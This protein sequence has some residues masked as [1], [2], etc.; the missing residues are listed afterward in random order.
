MRIAF[1]V[2]AWT[3]TS[4][5]LAV[6][7]PTAS[8]PAPVMPTN[9]AIVPVTHNR[10]PQIYDWPTR[11]QEVL[12][13]LKEKKPDLIL[14]G[15]SII[16]YWGGE[17]K[18]RIARAP[19]VW[20]QYFGKR[21]AVNLG[22][23]WDRTENVL[24]RLRNGE[25][26]G[27]APKAAVILIGVNNLGLNTAEEIAAGIAAICAEVHRRLPTTNIL[28]LGILPHAN[29]PAKLVEVNR[30]STALNGKDGVTFL[31]VGSAFHDAAGQFRRDLFLD[32]LHPNATGC[33]VLCDAIEPTLARLMGP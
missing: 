21:N 10:E 12:A 22:F 28:L 14:I 29:Q 3:G 31:D 1:A 18:H 16:H 11:H 20:T 26:D 8:L 4:F 2:I 30:L 15:D 33:R 25:L 13:C 5:C 23:G 32:G 6:G 27:I 9:T 24:W 7:A 17:P 19:D